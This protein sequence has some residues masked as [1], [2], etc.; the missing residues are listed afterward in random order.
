MVK[1]REQE[2][3]WEFLFLGANMDAISA[4]EDIGIHAQNS[5]QYMSDAQGTEVNFNAISSA[6]EQLRDHQ[7]LT[8]NWKSAVERDFMSR[9]R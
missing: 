1:D 7:P 2:D 5:V 3:A 8:S 4:A 9:K 6:L